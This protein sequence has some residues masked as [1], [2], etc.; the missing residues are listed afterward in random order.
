MTLK[1][2]DVNVNTQIQDVMNVA[3]TA[4]EKTQEE[5]QK[6]IEKILSSMS[7]A[8]DNAHNPTEITS[9]VENARSQLIAAQGKDNDPVCTQAITFLNSLIETSNEVSSPTRS[10]LKQM[11]VAQSTRAEV[12]V[13]NS[14]TA[15][16]GG[17]KIVADAGSNPPEP[18]LP[19]SG[20]PS[21][22]SIFTK[23]W[24]IHT[25]EERDQAGMMQLFEYLAG[26][27]KTDPTAMYNTMAA[28]AYLMQNGGY[29]QEI[30]D[31]VNKFGDMM[32]STGSNGGIA[33]WVAQMSD[34][35]FASGD[36][37][38]IVPGQGDAGTQSRNNWIKASQAFWNA[39]PKNQFTEAVTQCLGTP[40]ITNDPNLTWANGVATY[41]YDGIT[42]N[43]NDDTNMMMTI[44]NG[45]AG[46]MNHGVWIRGSNPADGT[47]GNNSFYSNMNLAGMEK[48][49][50][51]NT[52]DQLVKEFKD[53][54]YAILVWFNEFTE[55]RFQSDDSGKNRDTNTLTQWT[56]L[57]KKMQTSMG[58]FM[59]YNGSAS[60]A[61][62]GGDAQ[63]AK[64]F[65]NALFGGKVMVDENPDINS[66]DG[67]FVSDVFNAIGGQT[68][69]GGTGTL[70]AA[71]KNLL[72]NGGTS[73]WTDVATL[74]NKQFGMNTTPGVDPS[75]PSS[76]TPNS[77]AQV[78]TNAANTFASEATGQSKIT[79]TQLGTNASI[80]TAL[81]KYLNAFIKLVQ[82]PDQFI[83]NYHD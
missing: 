27:G 12:Y 31:M 2:L 76:A 62:G 33:L 73:E 42:Y 28:I 66:I 36:F 8:I 60:P 68:V 38:T 44:F 4:N 47:A 61:T 25:I 49:Y 3:L 1:A 30:D 29:S 13:G 77:E 53:P 9:I 79:T 57:A 58:E 7:H 21:S 26:P 23:S 81:L 75:S 6:L 19:P 64:D 67:N 54:M 22:P 72:K 80:E 83:R 35:A 52:F 15:A 40:T 70:E 55:G 51:M 82:S 41:N 32:G 43:W 18:T 69:A 10:K 34:Y 74:L 50:A 46:Y 37:G 39:L 45:Q 65:V 59:T 20:S 63:A 5:K 14:G 24:I 11:T 78:A 16:T 48:M 17:P 56:E 71:I